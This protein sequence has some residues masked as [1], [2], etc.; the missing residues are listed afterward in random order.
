MAV[1]VVAAIATVA[2][3]AAVAADAVAAVVAVVAAFLVAFS[4][5]VASL[6]AAAAGDLNGVAHVPSFAEKGKP[7]DQ[8]NRR[9]RHASILRH[10]TSLRHASSLRHATS[11]RHVTSLR[12]ATSPRHAIIMATIILLVIRTKSHSHRS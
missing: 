2:V 10:A 3:V 4:V 12:H 6:E 7:T 11:L 8:V 5:A 1:A 9:L